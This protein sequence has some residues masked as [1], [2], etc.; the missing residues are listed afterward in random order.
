MLEQNVAELVKVISQ[1][2]D[3]RIVFKMSDAPIRTT[4]QTMM[5]QSIDRRFHADMLPPE[6]VDVFCQVAEKVTQRSKTFRLPLG[7]VCGLLES[8]HV[9]DELFAQRFGTAQVVERSA[10]HTQRFVPAA[11][12]RKLADFSAMGF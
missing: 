7:S 11:G 1:N 8:R 4:I 6:Q 9:G 12:S 10:A 5:L 3:R 2:T